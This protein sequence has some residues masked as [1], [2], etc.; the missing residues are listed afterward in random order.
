MSQIEPN[1]RLEQVILTAIQEAPIPSTESGNRRLAQYI[2]NKITE[3]ANSEN[4]IYLDLYLDYY[5]AY[6]P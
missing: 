3:E 4:P 6:Q 1:E 2:N 5:R